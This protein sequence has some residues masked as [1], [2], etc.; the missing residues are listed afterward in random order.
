MYYNL[1]IPS[2]VDGVLG[3][4]QVGVIVNRATLDILMQIMWVPFHFSWVE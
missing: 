3:S 2:P 4:F 1:Y